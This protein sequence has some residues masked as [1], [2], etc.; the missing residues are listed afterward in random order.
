MSTAARDPYRR[1]KRPEPKKRAPWWQ[2][3]L[4]A[5]KA[6]LMFV[7]IAIGC[8]IFAE[9]DT[10]MDGL[11]LEN[12]LRKCDKLTRQMAFVCN[13]DGRNSMACF[14]VFEEYGEDGMNCPDVRARAEAAGL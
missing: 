9:V 7:G 4:E 8:W 11:F 3:D 14:E 6:L 13:G 12:D 10:W 2:P 5:R 1:A